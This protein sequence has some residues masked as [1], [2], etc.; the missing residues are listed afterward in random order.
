MRTE[1]RIV[2]PAL[3]KIWL[4]QNKNNRSVRNQVVDNYAEQMK[5]GKWDLTGQGITFDENGDLIDGQHR[6]NAVIKADMPIEMLIVWDAKRSYNYDCGLKRSYTDRI[7]MKDG[8]KLDRFNVSAIRLAFKILYTI[9]S[10]KSESITIENTSYTPSTEEVKSYYMKYEKYFDFISKSNIRRTSDTLHIDQSAPV[11]L[12]EFC[13]LYRYND[14]SAIRD[15]IEE[16]K[17]GFPTRNLRVAILYRNWELENGKYFS[18][19]I[20]RLKMAQL[21]LKKYIEEDDVKIL[22]Q[23]SSLSIDIPRL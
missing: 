6:L 18:D 1:V 22:K 14:E 21:S 23:T 3:A 5:S 9:K 16:V 20:K 7:L 19:R 12:A 11:R 15:W 8:I 2:T 17:T 4:Y 13:A 10:K